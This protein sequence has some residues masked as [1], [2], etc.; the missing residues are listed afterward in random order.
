MGQLG[1]A[2]GGAV[3]SCSSGGE[4]VGGSWCS[5]SYGIVAAAA[6]ATGRGTG[7]EQGFCCFWL[8]L[9]P[10]RHHQALL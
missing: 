8:Q 5:S 4:V 6:A 2:T 3:A 9:L 1:C 10:P 7:A